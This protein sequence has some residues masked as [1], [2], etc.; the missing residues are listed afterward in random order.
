MFPYYRPINALFVV[1]AS[2]AFL[3]IITSCGND[4]PAMPDPDP[5]LQPGHLN[6]DSSQRIIPPHQAPV[7]RPSPISILPRDELSTMSIQ[8]I[9]SAM[10]HLREMGGGITTVSSIDPD[11]LVVH[12]W[13]EMTGENLV[14][15][16]VI[17]YGDKNANNFAVHG[18]EIFENASF[19]LSITAR[20]PGY[21]L[22]TYAYT[23]GNI[24]SFPMVPASVNGTSY[25]FGIV[26]NLGCDVL[27]IYTDELVPRHIT[28]KPS[29]INPDFCQFQIPFS[30][31]RTH[32]FS[33]FLEGNI[34]FE[35]TGENGIPLKYA[36]GM[37][38]LV[39]LTGHFALEVPPLEPNTRTY[40]TLKFNPKLSPEGIVRGCAS[41]PIELWD[42]GDGCG[43]P[44]ISVIPTQILTDPERYIALGPSRK[45][46]GLS[47]L[48][49]SYACP[50][51]K[52][53]SPFDRLVLAGHMLTQDGGIDVVHMN[54]K[55]GIYG[56][57][58]KFSGCPTFDVTLMP[59]TDL[60]MFTWLNPIK[61]SGTL[62]RIEGNIMGA[63]VWKVT[64]PG[65][66]VGLETVDLSIPS[67]WF[68]QIFG[69][70]TPH[71]RVQCIDAPMQV[72]NCFTEKDIVM[73][74]REVCFSPW[75]KLS[76]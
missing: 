63:P 33:A 34:E 28:E 35:Q 43:N 55:A 62:I 31:Y 7:E 47:P 61:D 10:Y 8:E 20:V 46:T 6:N 37:A 39:W 1:F 26:N 66:S 67:Y 56:P 25:I 48:E 30:S 11:Q 70:N 41:I 17:A 68:T 53:S 64:L 2:I 42:S 49:L 73:A 3:L 58:L 60:P 21:A 76:N 40:Y 9:V 45:I 65:N 5:V 32:S 16:V 12:I 18:F 69:D 13:N 75:I 14:G 51:F 19:P 27:R 74:R 36:A 22:S 4:G 54:W 29:P 24:L 59:E 50:F 57:E 72:I 52:P 44:M 23:S 15:E 38:F 71:Y